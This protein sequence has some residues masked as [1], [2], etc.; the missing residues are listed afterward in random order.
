LHVLTT[1]RNLETS[2]VFGLYT[3]AERLGCIP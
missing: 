1:T 2:I 3:S